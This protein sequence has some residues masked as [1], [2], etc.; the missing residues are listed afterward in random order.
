MAL[1]PV[2]VVGGI[3]ILLPVPVV[4]NSLSAAAV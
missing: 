2:V 1:L 4:K 3:L